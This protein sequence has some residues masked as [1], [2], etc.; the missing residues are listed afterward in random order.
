MMQNTIIWIF[1]P[2]IYRR[3]LRHW[4][5]VRLF[6]GLDDVKEKISIGYCQGRREGG[7]GGGTRGYYYPGAR[8]KKGPRQKLLHIYNY[9]EI[10]DKT[11]CRLTEKRL[12]AYRFLQPA[13]VNCKILEPTTDLNGFSLTK[14]NYELQPWLCWPYFANLTINFI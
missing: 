5:Q 12:R 4:F 8:T 9:C 1:A 13:L 14:S 6:L 2:S 10:W 11:D 7:G 3:W